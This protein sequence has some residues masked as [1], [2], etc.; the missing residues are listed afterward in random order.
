MLQANSTSGGPAAAVATK[1]L[2][3]FCLLSPLMRSDTA[4]DFA[5]SCGKCKEVRCRRSSF[6]DGYGQ[7]LDRQDA[8]YDTKASVVGG[9]SKALLPVQPQESLCDQQTHLAASKVV[10]QGHCPRQLATRLFVMA[11]ACRW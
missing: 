9:Q 10:L 5:G 8:C 1:H 6:A 2:T 11:L 3:I 4:P 7:W